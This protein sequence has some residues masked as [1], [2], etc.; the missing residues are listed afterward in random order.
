MAQKASSSRQA[1]AQTRLQKRGT[2]V[3][4]DRLTWRRV[5]DALALYH[6]NSQKPLLHVV[7]DAIWPGMF[8]VRLSSGV[9]TDLCNL[10]R[11]KDAAFAIALRDLNSEMQEK[12]S[13]RL[14]IRT[15]RSELGVADPKGLTRGG[16]Q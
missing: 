13:D 11:A 14:Y 1:R 7:P 16:R 8:R 5:G 3:G 10:T 6:A 2:V 9:L 12:P 15:R 4:G